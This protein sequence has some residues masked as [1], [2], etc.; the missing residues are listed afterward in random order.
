MTEQKIKNGEILI[1]SPE[2]IGQKGDLFVKIEG[3]VVFIKEVPDDKKQKQTMKIKMM[4]V[5]DNFGI[6]VYLSEEN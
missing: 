3:F 2:G 1:I 4:V 5:K 6:A